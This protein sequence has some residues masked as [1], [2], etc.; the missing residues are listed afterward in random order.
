MGS[1]HHSTG[2][3]S[4]CPRIGSCGLLQEPLPHMDD[5]KGWNWVCQQ[6]AE[7]QLSL[8]METVLHASASTPTERTL[9]KAAPGSQDVGVVPIQILPSLPILSICL[10]WLPPVP[11]ER[12][13]LVFCFKATLRAELRELHPPWAAGDTNSNPVSL[14]YHFFIREGS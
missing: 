10:S 13:G 6:A 4:L 14:S 3:Q 5:G 11:F 1:E 2:P 7:S 9:L 8:Q 12:K